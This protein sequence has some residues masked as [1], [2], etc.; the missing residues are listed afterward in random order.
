MPIV[1]RNNKTAVGFGKL[2]QTPPLK[3]RWRKSPRCGGKTTAHRSFFLSAADLGT[4]HPDAGLPP[5]APGSLRPGAFCDGGDRPPFGAEVP[6]DL[7]VVDRV[8]V[9]GPGCGVGAAAEC[10]G[11]RFGAVEGGASSSETR[12][13]ARRYTLRGKIGC[14]PGTL[15]ER[16]LTVVA[17]YVLA[18]TVGWAS[19]AV[20]I[21]VLWP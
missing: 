20:V 10:R 7:A 13:V 11:G 9:G 1:S 18:C 16:A 14:R 4:A 6:H 12:R 3:Y 21:A 15:P 2:Q 17:I 8:L 5:C 19:M